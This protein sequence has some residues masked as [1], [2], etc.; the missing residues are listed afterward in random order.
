MPIPLI[1]LAIGA[2]LGGAAKKKQGKEQF[3]AVKGRKRRDGSAGKP[4]VSRRAT[5]K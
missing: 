4:Y 1:T 2:L 3:Q 5:S